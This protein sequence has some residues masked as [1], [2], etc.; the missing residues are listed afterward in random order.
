MTSCRQMGH[1]LPRPSWWRL[2]RGHETSLT[3]GVKKKNLKKN[4]PTWCLVS[5][6]RAVSNAEGVSCRH[7]LAAGSGSLR[8]VGP[9]A[10]YGEPV[11]V[12]VAAVQRVVRR[13]VLTVS[14]ERKKKKKTMTEEG[15][16]IILIFNARSTDIWYSTPSRLLFDIQIQVTHSPTPALY[17]FHVQCPSVVL[18][19]LGNGQ[20]WCEIQRPFNCYLTFNARFVTN[21]YW[22]MLSQPRLSH[23]GEATFLN[24]QVNNLIGWSWHYPAYKLIY[25]FH[26]PFNK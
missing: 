2:P 24:S 3:T 13:P 21:G 5:A 25:I 11:G 9:G 26:F 12:G 22:T 7:W 23:Q 1:T 20:L 10:G 14:V 15:L 6:A 17:W 4:S 16:D 8:A 19:C 18:V